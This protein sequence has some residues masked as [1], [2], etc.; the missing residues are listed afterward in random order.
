MAAK[1]KT[2]R[3][4]LVARVSM[5]FLPTIEALALT[6]D[7]ARS[8]LLAELIETHPRILAE[9]KAARL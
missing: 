9:L 7:V 6:E 4:P 2:L 8:R 1:I 5:E 3:A